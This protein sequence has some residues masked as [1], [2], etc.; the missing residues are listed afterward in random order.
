[1]ESHNGKT[2]EDLYNIIESLH[3]KHNQLEK[4]M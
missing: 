3:D 1:M 4:K 2:I